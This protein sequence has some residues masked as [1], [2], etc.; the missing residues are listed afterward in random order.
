MIDP[1]E[2]DNADDPVALVWSDCKHRKINIDEIGDGMIDIDACD[3][4]EGIIT[5]EC[6]ECGKYHTGK[7]EVQR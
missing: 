1:W 4:D 7:V 6:D 2:Q 5:W 3:Y